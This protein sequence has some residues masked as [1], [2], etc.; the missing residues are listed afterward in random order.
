M[1]LLAGVLLV[2]MCA[3][4]ASGA[5]LYRAGQSATA[6]RWLHGEISGGYVFTDHSLQDYLGQFSSSSLRG[7]T[8]RALWTPLP[9]LSA[10]AEYARLAE[11]SLKPALVDEYTLSRTGA[12]VKFTLSP[13]TNPRF[14]ILGGLGKSAHRLTFTTTTPSYKK[15]QN[16]WKVALGTEADIYKK[17]FVAAEGELLWDNTAD[18]HTLYKLSSRREMALYLRAGVR[19]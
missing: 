5:P 6:T 12:V 18:V 2:L 1:K 15:S 13:N 11:V 4:C 7:W 3:V 10:G 17:L 8:A 9:W 14:Y 16:Y 19:L